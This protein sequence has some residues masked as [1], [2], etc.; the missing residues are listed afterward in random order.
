MLYR[1]IVRGPEKIVWSVYAHSVSPNLWDSQCRN[2]SIPA[3]LCKCITRSHGVQS[4]F[5]LGLI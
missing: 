3:D 2:L 4:R 1:E 5:S